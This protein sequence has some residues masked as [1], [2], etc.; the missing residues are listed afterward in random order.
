MSEASSGEAPRQR[1]PS[2]VARIAAQFAADARPPLPTRISA[3]LR[4]MD[5]E[6]FSP[7]LGALMPVLMR[8]EV[9]VETIGDDRLQ[10]WAVI[11][12]A[13]AIMAGTRGR[14]VHSPEARAGRVLHEADFKELR[15]MRLMTARGPALTDQIVRLSRLLAAKE[16]LP[17]DLRPLAE[18]ILSEGIDA[19]R[20]EKARLDLAR[21]YYA[22]AA[23]AED[24]TPEPITDTD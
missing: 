20:A 13:V 18:L 2:T 16:K 8:A 14:R 6:R 23:E 11:V 21:S 24:Q 1:R 19:G 3:E 9:P 17:I 7:A 4:R 22:A 5:P 10:R 15:F 12:H